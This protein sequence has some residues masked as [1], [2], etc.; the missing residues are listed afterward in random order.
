MTSKEENLKK[1]IVKN[2]K[3]SEDNFIFIGSQKHEPKVSKHGNLNFL[4]IV[5][6]FRI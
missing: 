3:I 5:R 1:Y 4:F 2:G 6:L